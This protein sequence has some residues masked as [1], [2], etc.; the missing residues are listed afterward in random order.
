MELLRANNYNVTGTEAN[1]DS[2]QEDIQKVLDDILSPHRQSAEIRTP[3]EK[4]VIGLRASPGR[5]TGRVI[6]GSEGRQPEDF[7]EHIFVAASVSPDENTILYHSA[8]I[9]ATGGGILSHAGLIATQFNKPAIIVS[10]KWIR[11]TDGTYVLLFQTTEYEVEYKKEKNFNVSLYHNL[12]EVDHQL[13]NGDLVVLDASEGTLE[14]LGQESDTIALYEDFKSLGKTNEDI[15]RITDSKELLVLR[16]KKLHTRHQIEKLLKRISEPVILRYAIVEILTGK[17]LEGNK[18]T[19]EEKAYLLNLI[20][21]NEKYGKL[22][23]AYLLKVVLESENKFLTAC[24]KAQQIIPFAQHPFE[25]VMPRLE[26]IRIFDVLNNVIASIGSII[27]DEKKI[28]SD[29]IDRINEI[30][31]LSLRKL[32]DE[33]FKKISELVGSKEKK[34]FLR[35]LFRQINRVD[36][37]LG[38]SSE[39]REK[40]KQHQ[41]KFE[42]EDKMLC[43]KLADKFALKPQQ[44]A[45]ELVPL[46]GWKAA[47]LAE[48]DMVG[49]EGLIPS[50]FVITDKAFQTVLQSRIK[51]N[52]SAVGETFNKET[53]V[54][55][56]IDKIL[57]RADLSNRDKSSIIRNLWETIS[58]PDEI[59]N[60]VIEAYHE[61]EKEFL[62]SKSEKEKD[63]KLYVAIRSSSCEEDAEIAARAGEFETYL[64]INGEELLIQYLKRTWSGLWT[65]RAIHNRKVFGST[66][67]GTKGGVIVQRIVWSRISGVLQTINVPKKDLKEIV[68]NAGLGLGEGV[69]SGAVAADQIIVVK[70][71]NLERG[72]LKFNYITADK[73][74]QVVFNKNAGYGTVLSST[75]YHQR[76]RPALEYVELCEL[77][78]VASKLESAYGY[79]IDIE[80][81]IEGTKLWLLQVRPVATFLPALNETL[82]KYPLV[83]NS[84][85]QRRN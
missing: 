6:L 9:V 65:E 43:E 24:S 19:P 61:I 54:I 55:E 25:V 30:S 44:G 57:L 45:L 23:E 29:D 22:A 69:V 51:E 75:L 67:I 64:F 10:G 47:N 58:L 79:P 8:G 21:Q 77:V 3:G 42:L 60:E 5:A 33:I 11:E 1:I 15:S 12:H 39:E 48:L 53:L 73:N 31:L 52:F 85:S 66:S 36:L 46:I 78:S 49:G 26:A 62:T 34:E 38:T 18:S 32:R 20:L 40:I 28:L 35:H 41:K 37:L 82:K 81:G 2:L 14:V 74:E 76:F 27:P 59:K 56:V 17:F 4:I 13:L 84:E 68:I 7:N 16:G 71:G 72:P 70:E 50:W 80:F 63:A 83:K